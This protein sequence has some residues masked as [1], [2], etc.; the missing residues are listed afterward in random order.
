MMLDA[1]GTTATPSLSLQALAMNGS[2]SAMTKQ[3][4]QVKNVSSLESILFCKMAIQMT[5]ESALIP[6][7]VSIGWQS[8]N[9]LRIF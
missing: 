4:I 5:L 2:R 9:K 8:T 7:D 1:G 3:M 6:S